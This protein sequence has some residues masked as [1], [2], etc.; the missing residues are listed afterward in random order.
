VDRRR[1]LALLAAG[2]A[3]LSLPADA[4]AAL[5]PVPFDEDD[6]AVARVIFAAI[7]GEG[8]DAVDVV[9]AMEETLAYLPDDKHDLIRALPALVDQLSRVL[10]PTVVAFRELAPADREAAL[11]DWGTSSIEFRR[12]V[13]G[14]LRRLLL[15]HAYMDPATWPAIGYPG[16]WLDRIPLP[17]HPLRF[18]EL[19]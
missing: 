8:A 12:T 19:T 4:D 9:G 11:I 10:V 16:P 14:G 3:V 17:P 15:F 2:A 7:Y 13:Y 5:E 6:A 1:F 18:G